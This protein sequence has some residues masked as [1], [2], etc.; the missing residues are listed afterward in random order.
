VTGTPAETV[1]AVAAGVGRPFE[2]PCLFVTHVR[3]G[4]IVES[5]DDAHHVEQARAFG[6]LRSLAADLTTEAG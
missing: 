2:I 3:D 1:V 6:H 4:Q 5:R